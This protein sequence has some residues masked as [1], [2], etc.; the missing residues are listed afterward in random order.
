M[1]Q[2]LLVP[3][4]A[5]TPVTSQGMDIFNLEDSSA[6]ILNQKGLLEDFKQI[7]DLGFLSVS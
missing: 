7:K 4:K 6:F 1:N 3:A 5:L 2:Q